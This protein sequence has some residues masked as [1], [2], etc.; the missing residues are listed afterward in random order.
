MNLSVNRVKPMSSTLGLMLGFAVLTGCGAEEATSPRSRTFDS[1]EALRTA[2]DAAPHFACDHPVGENRDDIVGR[3]EPQF[4]GLDDIAACVDNGSLNFL[5]IFDD[6]SELEAFVDS[7]QWVDFERVFAPVRDGQVFNGAAGAN[8]LI[9]GVDPNPDFLS[10]MD[11]RQVE[12]QPAR[13]ASPT[14]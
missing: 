2:A 13:G 6:A 5:L 11:A 9:T 1:V 14:S 12:S 3:F 10:T 8:W 7:Q 4:A